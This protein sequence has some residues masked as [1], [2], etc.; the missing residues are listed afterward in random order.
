VSTAPPV[1]LELRRI[2]KRF[3]GVRALDEVSFDL[4]AGEVHAL[5]G[6]NGAGKSTLL[7]VLGGAIP[8]PHYEGDVHVGDAV[9]RFRQVRDAEH[10][11]IAVVFQELS[12]VGP[13]TVAENIALGHEPARGG[14]LRRA[15]MRAE[16]AR[17]LAELGADIDPDA[18]VERLG[19]GHQQLV[20]IAKALSRDARVLVFDEPTAALTETDADRL[21]ALLDRL[22]GRGLGIVYVSHRLGEVFRVSDRITVLRDGRSAGSQATR[23]WDEPRLVSAMVGRRIETLFPEPSR[24]PGEVV[25][26]VRGL[27]LDDPHRPGRRLLDEVG[28]EVRAGEVVGLAGLVGAGRSELLLTLAGAPPARRTG[29]IRLRNVPVRLDS[30]RAALD[31]GIALLT[32]DR[33]RLGLF[34]D[35]PVSSNLTLAALRALA[36][37]PLTRPGAERVAAQRIVDSLRIRAASIA[38]PVATLSG[39]NQQKV[40]LGRALL[41]HPRVLLLDEPTRGIDIAA[42]QEIDSQIDRLAREG[43]AILVASSDLPEVLGLS[44][45]IVVLRAGRV[46]GTLTRSEATPEAVMGLATG[47]AGAS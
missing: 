34:G 35:Q 7:R 2:S 20:E 33:K 44:D 23:D 11:G 16:A 39:G 14:F 46:M 45:R 9:A 40:L 26:S 1:L 30:P 15:A 36:A 47:A 25:L 41:T 19:V 10:A 5:V 8:W 4:R 3:G 38:A 22:R 12:L 18:P 29:D 42:R 27:S 24:V 32:E 37:G 13:L 43:L 28:L 21:L 17:A 31:L 6:E